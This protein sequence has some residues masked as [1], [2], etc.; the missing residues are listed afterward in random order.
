[1]TRFGYFRALDVD[2]AVRAMTA[3]PAARFLAGGTNLVDLIKYDVEWPSQVV[4]IGRLPLDRI[5]DSASGGLRIGALV[6]N[7]TL[8][9]DRRVEVELLPLD[10]ARPS[11]RVAAQGAG[12]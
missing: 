9:A 2:G 8:A 1:M 12:R 4:D 10:L 6:T 5:E 11:A 7:S 3:D